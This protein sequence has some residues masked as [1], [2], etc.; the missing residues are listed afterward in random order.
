M[1]GPQAGTPGPPELT[2]V[3]IHQPN[4]AP[5]LGYFYKIARAQVF[6]FLDDVSYSK[7]SYINRVQIDGGGSPR[8][9]TQPVTY[10]FGEPIS[11]VKLA[12]PDWRQSHLATLRNYYRDARAFKA[13]WPRIATMYEVLPEAN[14]ARTNRALIEAIA[15]EMAI[16]TKFLASS[17]LDTSGLSADDRLV[18]IVKTVAPGGRYLSGKGGASYQDPA[19]FRAAGIDLTYTE[20]AHP[21]YEQRHP[22]FLPGL[23]VLD[24]IF[25]VG[26]ADTAALIRP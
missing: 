13:A 11:E 2:V 14:L 8:W 6:V 9:L 20:F 16:A 26:F 21:V 4:Y 15:S 7:N 12:Q 10:K 23:S 5:W 3:A 18:A 19:K 24:S 1:R 22:E 25:N 17:D